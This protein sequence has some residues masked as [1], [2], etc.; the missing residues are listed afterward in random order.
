MRCLEYS[1]KAYVLSD[2]RVEREGTFK[3]LKREGL[4]K[5]VDSTT[6]K[7]DDQDEVIATPPAAKKPTHNSTQNEVQ[8]LTR[9][10][11]DFEVYRYY[12]SS[13]GPGKAALFVGF[14][15]LYTFSIQFSSKFASKKVPWAV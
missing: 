13:I 1:D 4:P 8:D 6:A 14:T 11:G 15:A 12:F 2:G 10:V 3:Q 7:V 5:G 9:V